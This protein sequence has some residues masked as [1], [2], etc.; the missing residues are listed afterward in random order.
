M[1]LDSPHPLL[2]APRNSTLSARAR[3]IAV[4]T[5]KAVCRRTLGRKE[6]ASAVMRWTISL[7]TSMVMLLRRLQNDTHSHQSW[8]NERACTMGLPNSKISLRSSGLS[9]IALKFLVSRSFSWAVCTIDAPPP[10]QLESIQGQQGS[11]SCTCIPAR[12]TARWLWPASECH[13]ISRH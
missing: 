11:Y 10:H 7:V 5:D 3:R 13:K 6:T 12:R 4:S 9:K 1:T 8:I 2:L